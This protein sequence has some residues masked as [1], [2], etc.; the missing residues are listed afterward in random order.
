MAVVLVSMGTL[1]QPGAVVR[2]TGAPSAATDDALLPL[3]RKVFE[4][5]N[6]QRRLHGVAPLHWS[7]PLVRQAQEQSAN[8]MERGFFAHADPVHGALAERLK[9]AGIRW[10]RCGESIFREHGMDDPAQEAVDGWMKS[11]G[12]RTS[13]LDPLF[14][15]TGVGIAISPTTEYFITQVFIR[16]PK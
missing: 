12:H 7:E 8:M 13:L 2:A 14:T 4:L 6:R 11:P 1:V 15:E 3:A 10:G 9:A 16:P 5:V